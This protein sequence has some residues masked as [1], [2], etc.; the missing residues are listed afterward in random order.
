MLTTAA[1]GALALSAAAAAQAAPG[2]PG[3]PAAPPRQPSE[4]DVRQQVDALYAQAEAA[5]ERYDGAR[6][7]LRTLRT[8]AADLQDRLARGQD[9]VNRMLGD[10]G[11]VAGAEYR[12]GG[13]DPGVQLMLS[14]DPAHYLD[15]ATVVD[16]LAAQQADALREVTARQRALAQQR[17][18][19]D[20]RLAELER[21]RSSLARDKR[22]I[23]D[24][25]GRARALLGTLSAAQRARLAAD[26][27]RGAELRAGR[28]AGRT[29]LAALPAPAD[30]RA[31][32]AVAAATSALGS[33]YFF[34]A[35]GPHAFDCSGLTSW[36]W[37]KAG[38]A[39]PR[40]SQGQ[41]GAGRRVPLADARPGDLVIY[42][43]DMHHVGMYVGGG[44]IIHAPYPGA[45]VR[46]ERVDTMPVAAVV[47]V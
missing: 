35:A 19:A 34:G 24:R 36:A 47:R 5:T 1:A 26:D 18:E 21:V 20:A 39:L 30:N 2:T 29:A 25:L 8:E 28:G 9:A 22:Q 46:Y 33:P 10:L 16:R 12:S 23:Q 42:Y 40:T 7:R 44:T 6:E 17:A 41:A 15:G 45:R 14:S 27:A 13:I 4:Q 37:A 38:V 43:G 32:A 11:Q 31:A 3:A